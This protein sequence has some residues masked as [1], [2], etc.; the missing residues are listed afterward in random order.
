MSYHYGD[1][2]YN[3]KM[4]SWQSYFHNGD[5]CMWKNSLWIL[6]WIPAT[7]HV[8]PCNKTCVWHDW[9]YPSCNLVCCKQ[10][11]IGHNRSNRTDPSHKSHNAS[12][13]YP[14]VHHFVTEMCTRVH[15]SV[16]KW[17]IV[18][19]G[20]GEF[21]NLWDGSIPTQWPCLSCLV[22]F[23]LV[24]YHIVLYYVTA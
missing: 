7:R 1:T 11:T 21:W 24:L 9:R 23:C 13:N 15:I 4:V 3:D 14:T 19:Y 6:K 5:P 12:D 2:N 20:T 22:L 10:I 8:S 17:C 16:T 18:G